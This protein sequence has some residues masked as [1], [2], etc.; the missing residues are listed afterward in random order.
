MSEVPLWGSGL[1]IVKL[2]RAS[3]LMEGAGFMVDRDTS[4]MRNNFPLGPYTK[5][6]PW[7][8]RWS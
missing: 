8:L 1:G 6:M 2:L 7:A 4:L 5:T 3:H